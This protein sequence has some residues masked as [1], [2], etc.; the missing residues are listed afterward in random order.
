[1]IWQ[2]LAES[3]SMKFNYMMLNDFIASDMLCTS[4]D[5]LYVT[6]SKVKKYGKYFLRIFFLNFI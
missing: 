3:E 6:S 2:E 5:Q 4:T 1:M